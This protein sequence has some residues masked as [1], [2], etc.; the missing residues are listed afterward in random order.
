MCCRLRSFRSFRFAFVALQ[1]RFKCK[2]DVFKKILNTRVSVSVVLKV[3]IIHHINRSEIRW[4]ALNRLRTE[5]QNIKGRC[6]DESFNLLWQFFVF[7]I[8]LQNANDIWDEHIK[9]VEKQISKSCLNCICILELI[10]LIWIAIL[11]I[12]LGIKQMLHLQNGF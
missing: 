4:N 2:S 10:T 5:W 9:T 6:L 12:H 3:D 7:S 1:Q 8:L 11:S